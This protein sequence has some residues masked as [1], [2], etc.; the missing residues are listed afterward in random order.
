MAQAARPHF[1]PHSDHRTALHTWQVATLE[2][3]IKRY[4]DDKKNYD[5]DYDQLRVYRAKVSARAEEFERWQATTQAE[6]D[7][8]RK[9]SGRWDELRARLG[10]L[11]NVIIGVH[12]VATDLRVFIASRGVIAS[13]GGHPG[14]TGEGRGTGRSPLDRHARTAELLCRTLATAMEWA[15][16]FPRVHDDMLA[17]HHRELSDKALE[18]FQLSQQCRALQQQNQCLLGQQQK[19]RER[20]ELAEKEKIDTASATR[21]RDTA[22]LKFLMPELIRIVKATRDHPGHAGE[23]A[24]LSLDVPEQG[25]E[26]KEWGRSVLDRHIHTHTYTQHTTHIHVHTRTHAHTGPVA[27]AG[28]PDNW[29]DFSKWRMIS[30]QGDLANSLCADRGM[31]FSPLMR[32]ANRSGCRNPNRPPSLVMQW[33]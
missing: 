11:E 9:Q 32:L 8:L 5:S 22:A 2:A 29:T 18:C 28:H 27:K 10:V 21:T 24:E 12:R 26:R 14:R 6:L 3:Q 16:G 7:A 13:G 23:S 31:S 30:T 25:E 17:R 20:Q 1:P 15:K 19:E 33:P 4:Q